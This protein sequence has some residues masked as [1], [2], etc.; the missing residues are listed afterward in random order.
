MK[1]IDS[2]ALTMRESGMVV[3]DSK[4]RAIGCIVRQQNGMWGAWTAGR[5]GKP[6]RKIGQYPSPIAGENAVHKPPRP[7][8]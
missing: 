8:P 5:A 2:S 6:G 1:A 3:R 4:G 7:T